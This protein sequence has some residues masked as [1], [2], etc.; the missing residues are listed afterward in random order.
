[1]ADVTGRDSAYTTM[2]ENGT[3]TVAGTGACYVKLDGTFG[4]GTVTV[5][6]DVF[7]AFTPV[8]DDSGDVSFTTDGSKVMAYPETMQVQ[9]RVTLSGATSPNLKAYIGF[10]E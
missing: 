6:D 8:T 5:S 2:T 4:S 10:G 3:L 7:D 1:M 9:V